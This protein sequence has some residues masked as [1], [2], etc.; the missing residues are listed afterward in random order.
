MSRFK[1]TLITTAALASAYRRP[2]QVSEAPVRT[3]M[4][5]KS[6]P[7]YILPTSGTYNVQVYSS[8]FS[9]KGTYTVI[10]QCLAS[11]PAPNPVYP[12]V[13]V[14]LTGC[15]TACVNGN[16]FSATLNTTNL[17][18]KTTELKLG[19]ILRMAPPPRSVIH[20]WRSRGN[21]PSMARCSA[22]RLSRRIP[23]AVGRYAHGSSS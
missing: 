3:L 14:A 11:C 5:T 18:N 19:F 17:P 12:S 7:S 2:A 13:T 16:T 21:S 22:V 23:G 15:T 4:A 9:E 8:S 20:T 10:A 1:S 6:E